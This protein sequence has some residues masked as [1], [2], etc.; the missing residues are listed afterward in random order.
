LIVQGEADEVVDAAAVRSW[1]E[2]MP[3]SVRLAML[4]GVGHFFH[5]KLTELRDL[6]GQ[7][8][9]GD[10]ASKRRPGRELIP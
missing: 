3:A 6:I 8:I 2:S 4:P 1:A 5:G 9:R 7:E 10:D